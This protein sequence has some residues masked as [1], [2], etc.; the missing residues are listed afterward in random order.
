M[1]VPSAIL[2]ANTILPLEASPLSTRVESVHPLSAQSPAEVVSAPADC[3][4]ELLPSRELLASCGVPPHPARSIDIAVAASNRSVL[5]I[6][7]IPEYNSMNSERI[8]ELPR[9][10]FSRTSQNAYSTHLGE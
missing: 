1:S 3:C 8:A 10:P 4:C 6:I 7:A 9:T 2:R 5:C